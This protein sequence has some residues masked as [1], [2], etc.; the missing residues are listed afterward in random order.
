[1]VE[2]QDASSQLVA[3]VAGARPG[4]TVLDYCAGGGGKTLALAA[5]MQG[6]GRL[7]AWD[8]NPRRMADL[9]D[10]ARR[11]GAEVRVLSDAEIAALKP[12]CDLVLVDAPC[13]GTGAWRRK[14]EGKWRLTPEELAGYPP[15]QDAILD[16]A[17]A[18]VKPG[19]RLVYSTCS[20]LARENED[21]RRRL[22]RP[23]PG[24]ATRGRAP[25]EPP[26]RRRRLLHRRLPRSAPR[27]TQPPGHLR[28][29]HITCG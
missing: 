13:S 18:R 15:L 26:R 27:L 28:S 11:A 22:R 21:A 3:E 9:P 8:A 7:L 1:M 10:R 19:G 12:V 23:P 2:L 6:R 17:A 20:L 16:A 14:P 4:M 5:A 24:L 25:P 29:G